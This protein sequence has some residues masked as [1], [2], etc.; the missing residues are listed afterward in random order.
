MLPSPESC[1]TTSDTM[2]VRETLEAA[3]RRLEAVEGHVLPVLDDGR[4]VGLLTAENMGEF[5]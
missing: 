2:T 1:A 3:L 4:L 5:S